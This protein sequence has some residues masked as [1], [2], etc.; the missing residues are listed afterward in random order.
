M[1]N[2]QVW[3]AVNLTC[4]PG[5]FFKRICSDEQSCHSTAYWK[6]WSCMMGFAGNDD[7][8]LE[9]NSEPRNVTSGTFK[10][11]FHLQLNYVFLQ[12]SSIQSV[13][14][15]KLVHVFKIMH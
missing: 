4:W 10:N 3:A 6:M 13:L 9:L 8:F 2:A 7:Q 12:G 15:L 1:E 5:G 11:I 14:I